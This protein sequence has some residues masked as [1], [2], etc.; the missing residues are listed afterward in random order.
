MAMKEAGKKLGKSLVKGTFRG[1]VVL[2]R[3]AS[4]RVQAADVVGSKG[5]V[6][7][8]GA[9]LRRKLGLRDTWAYFTAV[10]T[11]KDDPESGGSPAAKAAAADSGGVLAG[12][13]VPARRGSEVHVQRRLGGRWR[14]AAVTLV[15]RGGVYRTTV[16]GP[17]VYRVVSAGGVV[18]PAV[19][20]GARSSARP[21]DGGSRPGLCHRRGGPRPGS[22]ACAVIRESAEMNLCGSFLQCEERRGGETR[23]PLGAN[24]PTPHPGPAVRVGRS[25]AK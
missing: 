3:G 10:S 8:T 21:V 5:R 17:G 16:P 2:E 7:T 13:I 15:G 18:G 4:P 11:H 9:T 1:I 6:R 23:H 22:G 25:F 24:R 19:A 12:R 20:S 14:S